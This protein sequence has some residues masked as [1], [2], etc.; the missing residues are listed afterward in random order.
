MCPY[1]S[2][3]LEKL[4]HASQWYFTYPEFS[5][6]HYPAKEQL[7]YLPAHWFGCNVRTEQHLQLPF[8]LWHVHIFLFDRLAETLLPGILHRRCHCKLSLMR[9]QSMNNKISFHFSLL[10]PSLTGKAPSTTSV[11]LILKMRMLSKNNPKANQLAPTNIT[12]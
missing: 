10:F 11:I 9:T 8:D 6:S 1:L 5:T 7:T 3:A 2:E 12:T 4:P